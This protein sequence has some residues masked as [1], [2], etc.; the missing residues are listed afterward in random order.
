M[1]L[2]FAENVSSP[3]QQQQQSASLLD[4]DA[5]QPPSSD[6]GEL[7]AQLQPPPSPQLELQL[8]PQEVQVEQLNSP[9]LQWKDDQMAHCFACVVCMWLQ[10]SMCLP[11]LGH[12]VLTLG[13]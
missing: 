11:D 5:V 12:T 10:S 9:A 1:L 2:A 7:L 3:V 4:A 13:S 8:G 6:A